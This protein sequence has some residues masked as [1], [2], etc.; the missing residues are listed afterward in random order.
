[1]KLLIKNG[2]VVDPASGLDETL[3]ILLERGKIAE[4]KPKIEAGK[5]FKVVD[6]SRL[7]VAPGFID[8]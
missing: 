1:M 4:L 6:A 2:R 7:V 8:M 5:D 3:D